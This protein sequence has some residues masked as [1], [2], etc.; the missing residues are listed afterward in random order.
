MAKILIDLN[1]QCARVDFGKQKTTKLTLNSPAKGQSVA[2]ER[3]KV[4]I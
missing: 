4:L 3:K 1:T 2:L